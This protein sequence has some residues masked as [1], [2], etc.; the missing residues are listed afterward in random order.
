MNKNKPNNSLSPPRIQGL[1]QHQTLPAVKVYRPESELRQPIKLVKAMW[2]DLLASRELAWQLFIRDI[3]TQYR[4]SM[5]G[6]FWAF[7][8]PIVAAIGLT[9]AKNANATNIA[10]TELP[11]PAYVMLSMS[12]WQTFT[13][14][15]LGP[16]QAVTQAK[17]MIVRINFPREALILAKI[18]E[19]LFNFCIKL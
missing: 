5:L 1:Y 17:D 3:N 9:F 2:R 16:M 19:I 13:E 12:L 4:Q 18:A 15:V 10:E 7:V 6:V 14:S 11:Y 8:P